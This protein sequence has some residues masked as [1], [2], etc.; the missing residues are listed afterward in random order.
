MRK[1]FI[2]HDINTVSKYGTMTH[3][4]NIVHVVGGT[5]TAVNISIV[6]LKL[7]AAAAAAPSQPQ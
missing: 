3:G 5:N 1:H 7:A 2:Y 6:T 4:L